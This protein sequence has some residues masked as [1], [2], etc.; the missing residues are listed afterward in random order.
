MV[1]WPGHLMRHQFDIEISRDSFAFPPNMGN[2]ISTPPIIGI[3]TEV[4]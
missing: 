3:L 1:V 2:S 4:M